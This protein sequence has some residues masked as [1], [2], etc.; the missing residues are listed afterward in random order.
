MSLDVLIAEILPGVYVCV[1]VCVC[2]V[3]GRYFESTALQAAKC[4]TLEKGELQQSYP[5][6][7]SSL[8]N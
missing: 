8:V 5:R 4:F 2:S 3:G 1:C 7:K 6:E